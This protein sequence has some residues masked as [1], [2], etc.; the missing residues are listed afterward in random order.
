MTPPILP[1]APCCLS[2][3]NLANQCKPETIANIN[4]H[5]KSTML[6]DTLRKTTKP[7]VSLIEY[8]YRVPEKSEKLVKDLTL[9]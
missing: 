3:Q 1:A 7:L 5:V 9:L 4:K 6:S 2:C 8:A